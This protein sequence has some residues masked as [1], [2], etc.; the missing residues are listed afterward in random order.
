M[1]YVNFV[2]FLVIEINLQI[3]KKLKILT[4]LL[5]M[6]SFANVNAQDSNTD[7]HTI[8]IT[9]PAV[10][11]VDIEPAASKNITMGFSAPT[12]AGEKV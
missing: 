3:M 9:I 10:A 8:E 5:L 12:E 1:L 2:Y 4:V 7:S 6:F 11:L